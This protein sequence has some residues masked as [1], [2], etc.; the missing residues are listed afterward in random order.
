[1]QI[2][3]IDAALQLCWR[4]GERPYKSKGMSVVENLFGLLGCFVL[5]KKPRPFSL[6]SVNGGLSS[7][8]HQAV[9]CVIQLNFFQFTLEFF[10]AC[11]CIRTTAL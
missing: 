5:L 4:L 8:L 10:K 11:Y 9:A 3:H 2:K 6:S 1:M 7:E